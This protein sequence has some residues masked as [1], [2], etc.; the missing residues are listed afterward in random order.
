M[1]YNKIGKKEGSEGVSALQ[2]SKLL[3]G[4]VTKKKMNL[5]TR[6]VVFQRASNFTGEEN[7]V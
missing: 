6:L 7:D 5:F 4:F 1:S 3:Y 2:L